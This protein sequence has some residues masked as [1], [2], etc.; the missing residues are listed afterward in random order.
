MSVQRWL[1]FALVSA[2]LGAAAGQAAELPVQNK[3][4]TNAVA[5]QK[6]DIAGFPGVVA[7][8][9]VCVR[10]SGYVSSQFSA[11][12]LSRQYK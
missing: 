9:G 6:C 4:P 10:L 3:K 1:A 12:Q 11:G 2:L 8:N 5:T 7:A